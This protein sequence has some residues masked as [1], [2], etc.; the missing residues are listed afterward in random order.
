M[1]TRDMAAAPVAANE[2]IRTLDIMR[3]FALFGIL[4]VNFYGA[5]AT[6]LPDR[7]ANFVLGFFVSGKFYPLFS[8]LFGLGFGIML[9]RSLERGRS[10][11][12]L[13]MRRLLVLGAL[14]VA[15]YILLWDG[16]ILQT[17]ALAGALLL[18]FRGLSPRMLLVAAAAV[19]LIASFWG[20]YSLAHPPELRRADLE[21]QYLAEMARVTTSEVRREATQ[22]VAWARADG[23][24]ADLVVA[25]AAA[26]KVGL[27]W[28]VGVWIMQIFGM[29]LLGLY[30]AKRRLF[31][32]V[33]AH[34]RL[35]FGIIIFGAGAGLFA[36][37]LMYAAPELEAHGIDVLSAFRARFG[38]EL[39]VFGG[40][41]LTLAYVAAIALLCER[42]GALRRL[43]VLAPVGQMGLTNYLLQSVVGTTLYYGYTFGLHGRV[44][45]AWGIALSA[46]VFACQIPLSHWWMARFRYG[47]AEWLWRSA[48]YMQLQPMRRLQAAT[49]P[50]LKPE[51][52]GTAG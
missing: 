51:V 4:L 26:W 36:N 43:Q 24:Y 10:V 14:G 42:A 7:V 18:L 25:R 2:R 30:A 38:D 40:P 37:F 48:T 29:F 45:P 47:P 13:Y 52:S 16:D 9:L 35:A 23:S 3:G 17:Y 20:E 49:E 41:A 21:S 28:V 33:A 12:P 1:S 46:A 8:F 6:G 5:G 11:V 19:F 44:G 15:H 27:P 32:N 31:E 39:W 50:L 22:A 34:R